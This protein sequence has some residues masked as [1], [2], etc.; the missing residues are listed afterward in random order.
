MKVRNGFVSNSSS[1]SFCIYG[2]SFDLDE[3]LEKVR[4][5]NFLTEDE[6]KEIEQ[7]QEDDETYEITELIE[8]KLNLSLYRNEDNSV[9]IGN[10]WSN[11]GDDETGREFKNK[12]ETELLEVFGPDI[13]FDT[14]EEEIYN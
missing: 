12:I 13:D 5:T 2:V 6:L 7:Y 11:V 4:A 9:W 3:M 8:R 10:S 1:S 14:Y